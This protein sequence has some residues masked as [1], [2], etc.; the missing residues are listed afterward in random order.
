MTKYIHELTD[1]E[2]WQLSN[3]GKTWEDISKLHPQP[4]WC[5]E[6]NALGGEMG[7]WSLV[8]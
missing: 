3:D 4:E 7:C 5:N 1:N 2:Y 8:Y 6:P